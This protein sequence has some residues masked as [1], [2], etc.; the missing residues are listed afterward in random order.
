MLSLQA[1]FVVNTI[2]HGFKPGLFAYRRFSTEDTTTNN[3]LLAIPTMGGAF[4]YDLYKNYSQ[5]TSDNVALV[6]IGFVTSFVVAFFVVKTLLDYVTRH[7]FALFAWWRI[8]VGSIGVYALD[9][10]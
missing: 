10:W 7:G 4:A 1:T 8:V 3:W 9:F 5:M 6:A 2:T